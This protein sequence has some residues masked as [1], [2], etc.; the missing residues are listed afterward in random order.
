MKQQIGVE[1][2]ARELKRHAPGWGELLPALPTL[3]G[4]VLQQ[5]RE[6]RLRVRAES[7]DFK[8][9]RRDLYVVVHR[10]VMAIAGAALFIC[11]ALAAT[12]ESMSM[13]GP[14]PLATWLLGVSGAVLFALA[15]SP[16]PSGRDSRC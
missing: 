9:L 6:G 14:L 2:M 13:L 7:E 3:V 15:W 4:E 10:L 5:A 12:M 11:A 8:G 1:A 16:K